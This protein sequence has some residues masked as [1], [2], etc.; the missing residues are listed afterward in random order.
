MWKYFRFQCS[1]GIGKSIALFEVSQSSPSCRSD[2]EQY[3][4]EEEWGALAK[5]YWQCKTEILWEKPV[6][7][8]V[9]PP[10]ISPGL[11]RVRNSLSAFFVLLSVHLSISLDNDQPDSHLLYFT[12]R[13]LWSDPLHVSSIIYSSSGGW[14]VLMQHLVSSLW[15]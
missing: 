12:I 5:W 9:G 6:T 3:W 13:L 8:H 14:I 2:K 15:K 4:D 11:A 1:W 10:R 7:V